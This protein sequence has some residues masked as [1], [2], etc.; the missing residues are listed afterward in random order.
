MK[1]N[2][3]FFCIALLLLS[4]SPVFPG[5]E[6]NKAAAETFL[7]EEGTP[8]CLSI[9]SYQKKDGWTP[10]V[11]SVGE[12]NCLL[13]MDEAGNVSELR[14]PGGHLVQPVCSIDVLAQSLVKD[15]DS[16]NFEVYEQNNIR[17]RW[18]LSPGEP[19]GPAAK[20]IHFREG[21]LD[22][23]LGN[24]GL[25]LNQAAWDFKELSPGVYQVQFQ[26]PMVSV[27]RQLVYE[28]S[29]GIIYSTLGENNRLIPGHKRNW[30]MKSQDPDGK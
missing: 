2:V 1:K 29:S 11:L 10:V 16:L 18:R 30:A 12:L 20:K 8:I 19:S 21:G 7:L 17:T 9:E 23:S 15:A 14:E 13:W 6:S 22:F 25:R 4:L 27:H 28:K 24:L 26:G 3:V 5:T